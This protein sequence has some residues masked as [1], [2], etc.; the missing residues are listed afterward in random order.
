MRFE[1]D[2]LQLLLPATLTIDV[3]RALDPQ[4]LVGFLL[5]GDGTNLEVRP[6]TVTGTSI[7]LPVRHFSFGGAATWTLADFVAQITPL[8]DALP[9]VAPVQQAE[10]LVS[11]MIS[12]VEPTRGFG[13]DVCMQTNLCQRVLDVAERSLQAHVPLVAA[14]A[15]AFVAQGEAHFAHH[16]LSSIVAIQGSLLELRTHAESVGVPGFEVTFVDLSALSAGYPAIIELTKQQALANIRPGLLHLLIDIAAAMVPLDLTDIRAQAIAALTDVVEGVLDQARQHCAQN[17]PDVGEFVIDQILRELTRSFLNAL[18]PTLA[19]RL[20]AARTSCRVHIL[21]SSLTLEMGEQAPLTGTTIGLVPAGVTWSLVG[22]A[23]GSTIDPQSGVFTAGQTTGTVTVQA[24]SVADPTL[25]ARMVVT[26]IFRSVSVS[27][28]TPTVA[29][30]NAVTFSVATTGLANPAV[31]W[32]VTGGGTID[33]TGLFT[34]GTIAGP[35]TVRATSVSHPGTFGEATV[36]VTAPPPLVMSGLF[37]S[38]L[39]FTNPNGYVHEVAIIVD[40]EFGPGGVPVVSTFVGQCTT[41]YNSNGAV[42]TEDVATA[43]FEGTPADPTMNQ[44]LYLTTSCGGS[45]IGRIVRSGGRIV[46]IDFTFREVYD[47]GSYSQFGALR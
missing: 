34:A 31:T 28:A 13:F 16:S 39:A 29:A 38:T 26:I 27:P 43:I 19:D 9:P 7:A 1:P 32:S 24:T 14:Q 23:L 6:I 17:D 37:G 2:G 11:L 42:V 45:M 46:E 36:T 33:Q 18:E 10:W 3:G 25:F 44:E 15:A 4:G 12:W 47:F 35:F 21:P 30:G 22:P 20:Q 5:E 40:A 41:T 8:L